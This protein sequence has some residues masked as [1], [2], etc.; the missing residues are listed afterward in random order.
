M[1]NHGKPWETSYLCATKNNIF[2]EVTER[3]EYIGYWFLP[4]NPDD[5]IAGRLIYSPNEEILLELIGGFNSKDN[6][7]IAFLKKRE[8]VTIIHGV[9]SDAKKIT[10][11]NC[12]AFGSINI[13]VSFPVTKY[14]CQY[15]IVGALLSD[16]NEKC[17]DKIQV[18]FS[19]LSDWL[20]PKMIRQ[21]IGFNEEKDSEETTFSMSLKDNF[22]IKVDVDDN[23][24]ILLINSFGLNQNENKTIITLSQKTLCEIS[25]ANG[26]SSFYSLLSKAGMFQQFLSL[27]MLRTVTYSDVILYDNDN[28]QEMRNSHKL[29]HPIQLYYKEYEI[30]EKKQKDTDFLFRHSDIKDIFP[31][32]IKKWYNQIDIAPI[33]WH[34]IKSVHYKPIFDTVDFLVI[35]QALEG[36]HTR[37][38]PQNFLHG[39][40]KISL[41]QRMDEIITLFSDI[42]L[43]GEK[44]YDIKAIVD[45]RNYYSHFYK[46]Q[47][48]HKVL[49]GNDLFL[50]SK[51]VRLLLI[52][53]VLQ[54][55][56][57]SNTE[58]N[59]ILNRCN[60]SMIKN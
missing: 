36:Y 49:V 44:K 23:T 52:C 31:T 41:E 16:V 60:N 58:I 30:P 1:E 32:I 51:N 6:P 2:N 20:H 33:R 7:V 54:V 39:K 9:T 24:S 3:V 35:V 48:D 21:T 42:K 14:H 17:F 40:K 50:L 26:K 55:I 59:E 43:V 12:F 15:M 5:K 38:M 11:I 46:K 29:I 8:K 37:F 4:D 13:S 47:N 27:A 18:D 22:E 45:S 19:G 57:F 34:L 10:L 25:C 53:C 28:Y 56:G